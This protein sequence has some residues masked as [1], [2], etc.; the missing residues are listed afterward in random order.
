MANKMIRWIVLIVTLLVLWFSLAASQQTP[1]PTLDAAKK[2]AVVD[3]IATLFN[4][5]YIF[6]ETARKV[7]EALRAKLKAGEFDE[8][9][10]APDFARAVAAVILDVSKD[11]HTGFAYNPA[12]AE[13]LRRLDGQSEEEAKKVRERQL[14]ASRRD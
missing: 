10:A 5:N 4:K 9:S 14:E 2:Q 8:A 11:R 12:M 3:E 6:A 13:D 7:E 1:P